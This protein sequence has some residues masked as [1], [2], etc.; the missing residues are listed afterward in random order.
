ME[1]IWRRVALNDL[2]QI[3]RY[4]AE[5]N[6]AAGARITA[7]IRNAVEQLTD[8][9]NLGRSGRVEGTRELVIADTPYIVA[10]R[11]LNNRLRILSVIH[12]LVGGRSASDP[13][14]RFFGAPSAHRLQV[15]VP[16]RPYPPSSLGMKKTSQPGRIGWK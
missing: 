1:I 12:V 7:M 2:E 6:P 13:R 8:H 16:F 5:E 14:S 11:V 3:R 10:Y 9:P 15:D 4:I